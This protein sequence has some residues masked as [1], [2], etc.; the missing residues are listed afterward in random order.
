MTFLGSGVFIEII[1]YIRILGRLL[2]Q[3]DYCVFKERKA[4]I[5]T[6]RGKNSQGEEI[7]PQQKKGPETDPSLMTSEGISFAL[8]AYTFT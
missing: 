7:H 8:L 1:N 4:D 5:D 6:H 3:Y 2:I